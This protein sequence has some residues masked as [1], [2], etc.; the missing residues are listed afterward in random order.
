M[1][2]RLVILKL[3]VV[4]AISSPGTTQGANVPLNGQLNCDRSFADSTTV[5]AG[6]GEGQ[7]AAS[8]PGRSDHDARALGGNDEN[9]ECAPAR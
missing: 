3:L 2:V 7:V 4:W 6:H 5:I 1:S 8:V 9:R